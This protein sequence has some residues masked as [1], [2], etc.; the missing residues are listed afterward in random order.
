[1]T[2]AELEQYVK[3][4]IYPNN[5]QE[6]TGE[7]LQN[8][9]LAMVDYSSL[10]LTT[11]PNGNIEIGNLAGQ[12]KEFMPAT[13]SGDPMH[14]VY[15]K[16]YGLSYDETTGLWAYRAD[17]GGLTDLTT[18]EV[19]NMW[20]VAGG[21]DM[22]NSNYCRWA[23]KVNLLFPARTNICSSYYGE[24]QG[25]T[26]ADW[27]FAFNQNS[28]IEVAVITTKPTT[29]SSIAAQ[30]YY[31]AG[32]F[33]YC[34]KLR[35]IIGGLSFEYIYK[36][37]SRYTNMF[38]QCPLLES[39]E[40]WL[41]NRNLG[42]P[43][44]PLLSKESLL[45]MINNCASNASFTITLHPDVYAK[46]SRVDEGEEQYIGEWYDEIDAALGDA[47]ELKNTNITLASA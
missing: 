5:E 27:N 31:C 25:Y 4:R 6:I 37:D 29:Y 45:F 30:P 18:E 8:T 38:T 34:Y 23:N 11:K 15:L 10:T 9:L 19:Q 17:E 46:C 42:F 22:K 24:G 14:Y 26:N 39:V 44:S 1:M 33:A 3:E 32:M 36:N 35:R 28:T 47:V 20:F 7:V 12:T 21:L 43:N 40:I 13:P 2:R 16:V 41:L